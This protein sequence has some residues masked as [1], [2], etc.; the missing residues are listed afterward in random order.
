MCHSPS[1]FPG[2]VDEVSQRG[3]SVREKCAVLLSVDVQFSRP[4]SLPPRTPC[5]THRSSFRFFFCSVWFHRIRRGRSTQCAPTGRA[6]QW[7]SGVVLESVFALVWFVLEQ[8]WQSAPSQVT[9]TES[10]ETC[11][12]PAMALHVF[13]HRSTI[14]LQTNGGNSLGLSTNHFRTACCDH[15]VRRARLCCVA[16]HSHLQTSMLQTSGPRDTTRDSP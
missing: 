12:I 15:R 2:L 9:K 6:S 14:A 3:M 13:W 5:F 11:Q 1:S 10:L 7:C 4:H 16:G 8:S